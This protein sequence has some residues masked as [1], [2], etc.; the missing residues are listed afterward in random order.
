VNVNLFSAPENMRNYAEIGGKKAECAASKLFLLGIAAGAIIGFGGAAANA[1]SFALP[2]PSAARIVPALVFGF[3][4]GMIMLTGSELFTGNCMI[5]VSVA[6]RRATLAG[7][8]RNWFYVYAGNLAGGMLLAWGMA[9]SGHLDYGG[10]ALAVHTIKVAASKCAIPF[11]QAILLGVFCNM[12]VCAGVLCSLTAKDTFG[13]IA[14]AY[15]PVVFFVI[16]GFEHSIAN[17]YYIPAGLLA[18]N[19]E[20]YSRMAGDAG[21]ALGALSWGNFFARNLL[22]VT[23]GNIV[24]GAGTGLLFWFCHAREDKSAG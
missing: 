20:T 18:R 4:L 14:G 23:I 7:M 21:L 13:R 17:M 3:C 12:L 22:P 16:G 2:N 10:G 6:A 8:L 11:F 19:A 9:A 1:A 5:A 15:L 24:G